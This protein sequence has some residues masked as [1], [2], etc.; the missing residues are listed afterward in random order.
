MNEQRGCRQTIAGII[1]RPIRVG[2]RS[3]DVRNELA[4]PVEHRSTLQEIEETVGRVY[5]LEI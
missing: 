3:N 2:A 1:E 5:G 4:Q